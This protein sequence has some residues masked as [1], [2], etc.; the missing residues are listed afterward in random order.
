MGRDV[1]PGWVWLWRR[2]APGPDKTPGLL[3]GTFW[4]RGEF[5]GGSRVGTLIRLEAVSPDQVVTKVDSPMDLVGS[6]GG[7]FERCAFETRGHHP[8]AQSDLVVFLVLLGVTGLRG[9][10]HPTP[11]PPEV[12]RTLL[13]WR[14]PKLGWGGQNR[15]GKWIFSF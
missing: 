6:C 4:G 1:S 2:K 11:P 5:R 15:R 7:S 9:S 8:W 13:G 3:F 10:Q 12:P 14:G